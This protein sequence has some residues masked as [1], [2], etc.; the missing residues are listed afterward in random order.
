MKELFNYTITKLLNLKY[1]ELY[2]GNT[3]LGRWLRSKA[4]IVRIND[5]IFTHAGISEDFIAYE[6]FNIEKINNKMRQSIP[7]LKELRKLRRSGKSN[8]F[9]DMYFGKNSLILSLIHI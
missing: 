6:N 2:S 8:N 9:Y 7:R 4:T 1:D 5:I 3:I